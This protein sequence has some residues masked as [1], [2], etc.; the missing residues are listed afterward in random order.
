ML[1]NPGRVSKPIEITN[2]G[3]LVGHQRR[4]KHPSGTRLAA[5]R[6]AENSCHPFLS[7]KGKRIKDE[8]GKQFIYIASGLEANC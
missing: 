1:G 4:R 8:T 3:I 5:R 2:R 6:N 7:D